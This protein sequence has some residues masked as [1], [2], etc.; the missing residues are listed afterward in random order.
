MKVMRTHNKNQ[1]KCHLLLHVCT[2][3]ALRQGPPCTG[4]RRKPQTPHFPWLFLSQGQLHAT[5]LN[6][7]VSYIHLKSRLIFIVV[8]FPEQNKHNFE[9]RRE[10]CTQSPRAGYSLF[11]SIHTVREV[12][13]SWHYYL[14]INFLVE[15]KYLQMLLTTQIQLR[16][17]SSREKNI[18]GLHLDTLGTNLT[19]SEAHS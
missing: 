7:E 9:K 13:N 3:A 19:F 16:Y 2:I 12:M 4:M 18:Q 1:T 11:M 10:D 14:Q 5:P 8:I 17:H 15:N 6:S